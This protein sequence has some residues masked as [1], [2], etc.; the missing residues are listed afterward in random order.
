M[1]SCSSKIISIQ[2]IG[3]IFA[4]QSQKHGIQFIGKIVEGLIG[5]IDERICAM[6]FEGKHGFLGYDGKPFALVKG[7]EVGCEV[8]YHRIGFEEDPGGHD[9][10]LNC[11]GGCVEVDD[12]CGHG[13]CEVT[14]VDMGSASILLRE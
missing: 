7:F 14:G 1:R 10:L 6:G 4:D 8:R 13:G 3:A 2:G 5:N 11:G 12:R 9:F